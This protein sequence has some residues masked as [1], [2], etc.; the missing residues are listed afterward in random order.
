MTRRRIVLA[1]ASPRRKQLMSELGIEFEIIP[2]TTEESAELHENAS[3]L[4][5]RLAELKAC[6]VAKR[7][8]D[9]IV[10]GADTVVVLDGKILGKPHSKQEARE[11][12][13]AL[14]GKTHEVITSIA[15]IDAKSKKTLIKSTTTK[16]KFRKISENKP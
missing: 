9:G 1:S 6:D 7:V 4:V 5:K 12:I 11:M 13:T 15:M 2:S 8:E 3:H 10:I 16:V 14:G